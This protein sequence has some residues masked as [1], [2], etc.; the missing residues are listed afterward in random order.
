LA[1]L[2]L[3]KESI[4]P[5]DKL[6]KKNRKPKSKQKKSTNPFEAK[7]ISPKKNNIFLRHKTSLY[8]LAIFCFILLAFYP[9]T[10]GP[11]QPAGGD[12][13]GFANSL[14]ENFTLETGE[15]VLWDLTR[16][17]GLPTYYSASNVPNLYSIATK[18][19]PYLG[20]AGLYFTIAALGM[21][22][23][24]R[25]LNLGYKTALFGAISIAI[26]PHW[27]CI[28][29]IGHYYKVATALLIPLLLYLFLKLFDKPNITNLTLYALIQSWQIQSKHYQIIYYT[30]ILMLFVG[31]YKLINMQG[32]S[33]NLY[34]SVAYIFLALICVVGITFQPLALNREFTPHSIRGGTG[35][36]GSTGLSRSYATSW[37]FS[38]GE[39]MT[40]LIPRY[41]GGAS[42]E[43]YDLR[44]GKY[45]HLKNRQIPGYW[46]DMPFTSGTDYMGVVIIL[47]AI[48]GLIL[49]RKNGFVRSLSF[50]A[51]LAVFLSFGRNFSLIY[52]IFYL[53]APGFNKF[54]VPSMVLILVSFVLIIF[55]CYG[56]KDIID[57]NK[58]DLKKAIYISF[59]FVAMIGVISFISS[60]ML[61]YSSHSDKY[62]FQTLQ[63]IKNIRFEFLISDTIR[64]FVYLSAAFGV[65]FFYIQGYFK[66]KKIFLGIMI[67]LVCIDFFQIQKR[68]LLEKIDGSYIN[69]SRDDNAK[70]KYYKKTPTDEFLIS[71][72]NSFLAFDEY[73]VYPIVS[74]FWASNRYSYYYQSIGGYSPA[75]LRI[76]QDLIDFG[77][78]GSLLSQ[79]I[80]NMLSC[81]Y[82]FLEGMLPN[83]QNFENLDLVFSGKQYNVYEN[84]EVCPKGWFVGSYTLAKTRNQRFELLKSDDFDIKTTAIL[85]KDI[86]KAISV[87]VQ[88]KVVL[89]RNEPQNI[90]F[91][92]SNSANSLLVISNV[93][94]PKGWR[95][96]IDDKETEI[97]KT[98][99]VLG[100]I[101]V[102][103]GDHIIKIVFDSLTLKYSSTIGNIFKLGTILLLI[104]GILEKKIQKIITNKSKKNL[105]SKS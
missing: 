56:L 84:K 96:Y 67:L 31:I 45:P 90:L 81:K 100:S 1:V 9:V 57:K 23:L 11:Y 29:Q 99:H 59:G 28:L 7:K 6:G 39:M 58:K 91:E 3:A 77:R 25:Y 38:P 35:E 54:R 70:K 60:G 21:F 105:S 88:A 80:T 14:N 43:T 20:W 17:S 36:E 104:F 44:L 89:K 49:N 40:L 93:Y 87:P 53:Y 76:Y 41:F 103:K 69:L 13:V 73:R 4:N 27:G 101:F 62:D 55:A 72:K 66:N 64:L 2:F 48:I 15:K 74:D 79:N 19:T 68:F 86:L 33:K 42:S 51:I 61:S 75:K 22:L 50:L 30:V 83:T 63:M 65:I 46:G 26:M 32:K 47:L 16:F 12:A 82:F 85:E 18:V 92:V 34:K 102:P 95:A 10:I 97:Y 5:G 52:D 8:I 37:S 71:K 24:I 78:V 94:Y 98:N